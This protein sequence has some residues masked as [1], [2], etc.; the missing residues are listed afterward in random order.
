MKKISRTAIIGVGLM[1]GSLAGALK[2]NNL[3]G[4]I[5]GWDREYSALQTACQADIIDT[6]APDL[7]AAVEKAELII[8]AV[9]TAAIT[10][11]LAKIYPHLSSAALVM[12]LGSTKKEILQQAE[13]IFLNYHSDKICDNL[14]DKANYDSPDD[15]AICN[16]FN[17]NTIYN[18]TNDN[19]LCDNS[20]GNTS[21]NNSDDRAIEE[22]LN[23]NTIEKQKGQKP[24]GDKDKRPETSHNDIPG[25]HFIGGH[26][27]AGSEK[28]G[29]KWS[30]PDMFSGAP[31]V[32]TPLPQ[33]PA[34]R[35]NQ[36]R[37]ILENIGARVY[38]FSP[39][40]HDLYLA[41]ISHLPQLAAS[42]LMQ[43]IA[44]QPDS[45]QALELAGSGLR[46]TT[47]IAA[48]DAGIW[49]DII[50]SNRENIAAILQDYITSLEKL[51]KAVENS[52]PEKVHELMTAAARARNSL[53][54]S[55]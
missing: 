38:Q 25:P 55:E 11:T 53:D 50:F 24:A 47:R 34:S 48:S 10:R 51:Q 45:Q 6:I 19:S 4:E 52:N 1:G 39:D 22:N 29:V 8:I 18:N 28:S 43:T 46:D 32:L 26:P 5:I 44:E 3:T 20:N 13:E 40:E 30:N 27:I 12:D 36:L 42:A 7:T 2:K 16:N 31:F 35:V 15:N 17:G 41:W 23:N 9:P 37:T 54:N 49:Q 33:T 14:N 21:Y